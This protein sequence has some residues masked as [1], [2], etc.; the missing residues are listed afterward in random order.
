M[1]VSQAEIDAQR[2]AIADS[3]VTRVVLP[4]AI[5]VAVALAVGGSLV[6]AH[7]I[8]RLHHLRIGSTRTPVPGTRAV[9]LQA[10]KYV[11]YS[12]VPI[13][14][15]DDD[16]A[17]A[18][19]DS[20]LRI[21]SAAHEPIALADYENDL[22]VTTDDLDIRAVLTV[23]IPHPGAYRITT[24]GPARSAGTPTVVLGDPT[25]SS[26]VRV[27]AGGLAA[28]FGAIALI[29]LVPAWISRRRR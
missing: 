9:R 11:I 29:G 18:L 8:P 23:R 4:V 2:A 21:D 6:V 10:Q 12:E 19:A 24:D 7:A 15:R 25:G 20:S 17:G 5:V 26:I 14:D 28:L 13:A 27:I 3:F 16:Q 22:H 1:T